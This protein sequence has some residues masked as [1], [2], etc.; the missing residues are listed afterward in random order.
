MLPT[1]I[2]GLTEKLREGELMVQKKTEKQSTEK[3]T[4]I[5]ANETE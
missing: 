5:K 3:Q 1:L 2:K 4:L